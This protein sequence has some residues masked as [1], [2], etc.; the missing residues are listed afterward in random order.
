MSLKYIMGTIDF[1]TISD[2]PNHEYGITNTMSSD[3]L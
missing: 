1:S 3:S 2:L